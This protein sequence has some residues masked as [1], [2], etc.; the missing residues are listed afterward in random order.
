MKPAV[1]DFL[2]N[3][4]DT[5]GSLYNRTRSQRRKAQTKFARGRLTVNQ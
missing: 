2:T 3:I 4:E 1:A 5:Q